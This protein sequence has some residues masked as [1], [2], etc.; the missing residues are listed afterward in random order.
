MGSERNRDQSPQ[1]D[2]D[3]LKLALDRLVEEKDELERS[4]DYYKTLFDDQPVGRVVFDAAGL[5]LAI[6]AGAA[7]LLGEPA[8][9]LI[10]RP[11]LVFVTEP[12][13]RIFLQHLGHAKA[14]IPQPVSESIDLRSGRK[15][16]AVEMVTRAFHSKT[17]G[18]ECNTALVAVSRDRTDEALA[19]V[20]PLLGQA[21]D[22]IIVR[23]VDG[24]I[25]GWN[26][27]AQRLYGYSEREVLGANIV[28]LLCPHPLSSFKQGELELQ[29]QD[30][31]SAEL[32]C[33]KRDGT[34][35]PIETRW[36]LLRNQAGTSQGVIQIDR[37]LTG[38]HAVELAARRSLRR[39]AARSR[40][41]LGEL[42]TALSYD[43][44]EPLR[45]LVG[46][47]DLLKQR[48]RGKAGREADEFLALAF[49]ESTRLKGMIDDVRA[50]CDAAAGE[51]EARP[52]SVEE[53]LDAALESLQQ[54]ISA[55]GATIQRSELPVVSASP[56]HLREVLSR[57]VSNALKFRGERPPRISV[58]AREVGPMTEISVADNGIGIG[59]G[60]R[61]R[62][63]QP[64][65]RLHTE[66]EYPGRGMGLA[67]ARRIVEHWG[68][69]IWF[70]STQGEGSKFLFTVPSEG[71]SR[72]VTSA[73]GATG[74]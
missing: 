6:N 58:N 55:T 67:I 35:I 22:A 23:T 47:L 15:T 8:T 70:E 43:V 74:R 46:Y 10:G 2:A 69:R 59:S 48:Y 32:A 7:E 14:G 11:F 26:A 62:L 33:R 34:R 50:Y 24:R 68:G 38:R 1:P 25:T 41:D 72:E 36:A 54:P 16:A 57:L 37:D 39:D 17:G 42:A 20:A 4:R 60:E 65:G 49:E 53:A 3:R 30:R 64:F 66:D 61:D 5:I 40:S 21:N 19:K 28:A 51:A 12:F 13:R 44:Q 31:W 73:Q 29:R 9:E 45:A 52:V 71:A 56:S 63:F 27:G 18:L